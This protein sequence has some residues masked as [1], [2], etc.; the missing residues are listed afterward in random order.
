[1]EIATEDKHRAQ[2]KL[3]SMKVSEF[4]VY[5]VYEKGKDG[6]KMRRLY[7]PVVQYYYRPTENTK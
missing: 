1:M 4:V 5:F 6:E 7:I 3:I 2:E